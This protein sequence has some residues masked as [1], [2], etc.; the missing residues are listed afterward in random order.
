MF[1]NYTV[2][3]YTTLHNIR[4]GGVVILEIIIKPN[5]CQKSINQ[6]WNYLSEGYQR[7]VGCVIFK[8]RKYLLSTHHVQGFVH[9]LYRI[10]KNQGE[11]FWPSGAYS[12]MCGLCTICSTMHSVIE[13]LNTSHRTGWPF[14]QYGNEW[15]QELGKN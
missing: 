12:L 14:V 2:L 4:L 3:H 9:V 7:T 13:A 15:L 10:Y 6:M 1:C 8:F 5:P 11:K